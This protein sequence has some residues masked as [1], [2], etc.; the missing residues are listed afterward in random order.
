M[1]PMTAEPCCIALSIV[2]RLTA[3][4]DDH[5]KHTILKENGSPLLREM[6]DTLRQ[7]RSKGGWNSLDAVIGA[8][9]C[10]ELMRELQLY[11]GQMNYRPTTIP[12]WYSSV[13]LRSV[14]LAI[15]PIVEM[16]V[17]MGD[18]A[19]S[20]HHFEL[21]QMAAQISHDLLDERYDVS[22]GVCLNSIYALSAAMPKGG[23]HECVAECLVLLSVHILVATGASAGIRLA[24]LVAAA[25]VPRSYAFGMFRDLLNARGAQLEAR[26]TNAWQDAVD[27]L[28]KCI[29]G[30]SV[31]PFRSSSAEHIISS[32]ATLT[33]EFV[34]MWPRGDSLI[35]LT[36]DAATSDTSS[37][38]TINTLWR[39]CIDEFNKALAE[40][41]EGDAR[42]L[43]GLTWSAF[44]HGSRARIGMRAGSIRH[45]VNRTDRVPDWQVVISGHTAVPL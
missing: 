45:A 26:C 14:M 18:M 19:V 38:E 21:A 32:I 35:K 1:L 17:S 8:A 12:E 9:M 44:I 13:L 2:L 30:L 6:V 3:L 10:N 28:E 27:V 16:A 34:N 40:Y 33:E 11:H 15:Q 25:G 42:R 36:T 37:A 39:A 23:C 29:P 31:E 5:S 7:W 41:L 24:A 43:A 4:T 22:N 20:P